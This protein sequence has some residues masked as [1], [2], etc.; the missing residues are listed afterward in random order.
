MKSLRASEFW[1]PVQSYF[2]NK[3]LKQ[4]LDSAMFHQL[5]RKDISSGM[6]L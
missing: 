2:A 3:G 5:P 1:Q 6:F 4:D